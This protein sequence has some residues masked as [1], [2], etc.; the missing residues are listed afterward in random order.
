MMNLGSHAT[1]EIW[2]FPKNPSY[3]PWMLQDMDDIEIARRYA[4]QCTTLHGVVE[5]VQSTVERKR[6]LIMNPE[7]E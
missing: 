2:Y 6:V 7:D 1:Y 5:I 3:A 4:E